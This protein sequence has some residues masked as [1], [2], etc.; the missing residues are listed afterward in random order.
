MHDIENGHTCP[1]CHRAGIICTIEDGACENEGMC[2]DCLRGLN[3]F[4]GGRIARRHGLEECGYCGHL[5]GP[6][7]I[8]THNEDGCQAVGCDCQEFE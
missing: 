4:D 8:G 5:E 1:T 7:P 3:S 2:D 6:P